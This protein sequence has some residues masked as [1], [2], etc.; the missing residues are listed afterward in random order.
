[1]ENLG[2]YDPKHVVLRE[3]RLTGEKRKVVHPR[4]LAG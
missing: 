1:V 2:Q 4:A 3:D